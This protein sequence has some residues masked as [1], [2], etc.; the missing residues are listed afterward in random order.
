M[1]P[2][3]VWFMLFH[4]SHQVWMDVPGHNTDKFSLSLVS[5]RLSSPSSPSISSYE[6]CSKPFII[7]VAKLLILVTEP[8]CVLHMLR[9]EG[10]PPSTCTMVYQMQPSMLLAF[11][12]ARVLMDWL[13]MAWFSAQSL[14]LRN[15]NSPFPL[16]FSYVETKKFYS[17]VR[18]LKL[19]G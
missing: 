5:S 6:R 13:S 11:F 18:H 19:H 2:R 12:A 17:S 16:L 3:R 9:G 7:F 4:L 8:R 14:A 1:L 10:W 15:H